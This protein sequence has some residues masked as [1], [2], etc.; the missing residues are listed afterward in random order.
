MKKFAF[1]LCLA[2]LFLCGCAADRIYG[3]DA[4]FVK[5][6]NGDFR[7]ALG[8][9][10]TCLAIEG[11]LCYLGELE[12]VGGVQGEKVSFQHLGLSLQTGMFAIKKGKSDSVL[13]RYAPHNEFY[14]IYRK[15]DLPEFDYSVENCVRLE[16]NK[17]TSNCEK[18]AVHKDCRGGITDQEKIA[19]FLS[20]IRK[21]QDPREAGLYD[22]VTKPDGMYENCYLAG[23][24]YGFFEEEPDLAIMMEVYS[25]NDLA[26]S[27]SIEEKDYVF[28]EEW[29]QE[30]LRA[31]CGE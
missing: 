28:P 18:D 3:D 25:F 31:A 7:D 12:F 19:A 15:A 17:G 11:K 26:Y 30:F 21:Q 22:L 29:R 9:E 23:E 10:Y 16:W 27:V 24:I 14:S 2:F 6:E 4:A 20:E 8:T 1:L 5:L 13:I